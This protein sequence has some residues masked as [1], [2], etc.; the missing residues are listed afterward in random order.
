LR[1]CELQGVEAS[2]E[3]QT[4][5]RKVADENKKLRAMLAHNGIDNDRIELFLTGSTCPTEPGCSPYGFAASTSVQ[6][7]EDSL[8]MRRKCCPDRP[9]PAAGLTKVEDH[10]G[11]R[12]LD[13]I[14]SPRN[15]NTTAES[16]RLIVSQSD[17]PMS[18]E[19]FEG[20]A[21]TTA[22]DQ[23]SV[24]REAT[25]HRLPRNQAQS[26]PYIQP[27]LRGLVPKAMPLPSDMP[28]TDNSF[29]HSPLT[30][31]QNTSQIGFGPRFLEETHL[32]SQNIPYSSSMYLPT[33]NHS[34]NVNNCSYAAE[35][36]TIMAG[37]DHA[38]VR[39]DLGCLSNMDCDV[40]NQTVFEVMDR[41]SD[42][43]RI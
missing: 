14:S 35:M 28:T 31:T 26:A 18:S 11:K 16:S 27:S 1:Q 41:Y 19:S 37:A 4:A 20:L 21:R 36:I 34:L 30:P 24:S 29:H 13:P 2:A 17:S 5:A 39:A 33:T 12:G 6:V 7:L 10:G 42:H 8:N 43:A 40:D 38:S 22:A 9:G 3:I 32:Q 23:V 25:H 15:R